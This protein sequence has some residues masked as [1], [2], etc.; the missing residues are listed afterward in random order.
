[1]V[2]RTQARAFVAQQKESRR[3][4]NLVFSIDGSLSSSLLF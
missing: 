2:E 3:L 1:M 4:L